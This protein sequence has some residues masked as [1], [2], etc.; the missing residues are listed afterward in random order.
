MVPTVR[1]RR[2]ESPPRAASRRDPLAGLDMRLTYRTLRVLTAIAKHPGDT[3]RKIGERS[4]IADDGQTSKLLSRL[5]AMNLIENVG[6]PYT[7]APKA[8]R[9]TELGQRLERA[10]GRNG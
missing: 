4:G 10:A 3:N 7:F 2:E 8:W 1:T 5:A 9:L 6:E